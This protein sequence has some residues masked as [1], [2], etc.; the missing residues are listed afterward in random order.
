[1]K[2]AI[3]IV[4]H[5]DLFFIQRIIDH[6]DGDFDFY[7]HIDKNCHEEIPQ[8]YTV[9]EL[10]IIRNYHVRW[11]S[12]KIMWAIYDLLSLASK[13]GP[14]SFFHL[15]TGNCYPVQ[16][17]ERFKTFFSEQNTNCYIE[18]HPMPRQGWG[19]EGGLER[20]RY[21]WI[22]NQHRDIRNHFKL[23][24]LL[25][26][27]QRKTG[28]HRKISVWGNLYCGGWQ[29]SLSSQGVSA[30]LAM[31]HSVLHRRTRYT[32]ACEEIV[33]QTILL[34]NPNVKCINNPMHLSIFEGNAAS[35]KTL[36]EADLPVITGGDF[37]FVRKV[38]PNASSTL[39]SIIDASFRDKNL[40]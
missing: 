8:Y 7:L 19:A 12:W 24:N 27:I 31:P 10:H 25:L 32:H 35:P 40:F 14:Y 21:Y 5:K 16:S 15:I 30:I 34:N 39:L 11:G 13:H 3:L 33:P 22:G 36:T 37:F 2:Q 28:V 38:D 18:Y 26:K 17:L 20:I 1:M 23:T 9:G 4:A 29:S 6:F